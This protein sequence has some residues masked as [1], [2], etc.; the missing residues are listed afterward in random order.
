MEVIKLS[1]PKTEYCSEP[2]AIQ[3]EEASQDE[4]CDALQGEML[5]G[6]NEDFS[7]S[8]SEIRDGRS[9]SSDLAQEPPTPSKIPKEFQDDPDVDEDDFY[10]E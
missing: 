2:A 4:V 5:D 10:I 6:K 8:Q 9:D 1:L 3:E 7:D